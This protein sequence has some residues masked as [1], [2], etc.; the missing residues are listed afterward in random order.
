MSRKAKPTAAA[1]VRCAIYTRKSSEEGLGLELDPLAV[2]AAIE[3]ADELAE[4]RAELR[5]A[6]E[7]LRTVVRRQIKAERQTELTDVVFV[8]A[9]RQTGSYRKAAELLSER[10]GQEVSKDQVARA[11]KR[12]G[13][14]KAV[15][16]AADSDSILLSGSATRDRR[17]RAVIQAKA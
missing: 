12:S 14:T 13:G 6:E 17:S 9:Y 7:R 5:F 8:E 10:V 3:A 2:H 4:E 15:Y 1:K 11:V 16:R